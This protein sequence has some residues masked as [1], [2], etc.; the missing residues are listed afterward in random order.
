MLSLKE[1]YILHYLYFLIIG[2]CNSSANCW[3]SVLELIYVPVWVADL[4]EH[5]AADL[6][7][8]KKKKTKP[9]KQ[10]LFDIHH[11]MGI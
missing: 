5:V 4:F 11:T 3:F 2:L 9:L 6:L 7:T 1:E 8:K 10:D